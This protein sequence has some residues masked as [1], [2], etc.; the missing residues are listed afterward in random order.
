[1]Q[2]IR[3]SSAA[4]ATLKYTVVILLV[5]CASVVEAQKKVTLKKADQ[6]MGGKKGDEKYQ[7]LIGNVI[8]VQNN[9]TIYCDS[10]HFYKKRNSVEAFG[11]V[12]IVEGDSID[13]TGSRLEYDGN[14]KKAKLR[15]NVVFTKLA[16]ATLYTDYLDF[17]R[18]QNLAYYF[19]GGK[20][21][22][23][24]NTLTSNKGYYKTNTNLASFKKNVD[25]KN[26]DYTMQ[27]DSLQ[28]NSRTKIIYF[29]TETTVIN[30]D[31]STFVYQGGIY[32][33]V[34]KVSDVKK[35]T[36][37]SEAYTI[38]GERYD[39]DGIRNVGKVRGNVVMT[40]KKENLLIYGQASDHFKNT[41]YTKVYD[42]AY[43]A[44]VTEDN[45]TLFMSADTLISIDNVDPKKKRLLAY[46]NVKIFKT[47]MQGKADS[48]EYR[49]SDSTI[50]FYNKPVLW[51]EGNQMTADSI[52]ML[53]EHNTIS[54]IFLVANAFVISQDTLLNFNQI[55]GRRMTAE[56]A[57][58]KINKVI[59]LGNGESVYYALDD[60]TMSLMGMNKIICSNITI[61]FKEGKV[62]NLSFYVK[63]DA[64]FIPP[65][66]LKKEMRT[67]KGFN[68]KA[69]EKPLRDDV[70][71]KNQPVT[72][73]ALPQTKKAVQ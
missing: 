32:N 30:K 37:E 40:S 54:K 6:L 39:Y 27:A 42:H 52:R 38:V 56:L 73:P 28:Y 57:N 1:M 62:N 2:E 68:W 11:Y 3:F 10:A 7:R 34:S 41:G 58:S 31:S 15:N 24:L 20:L 16:T 13:I 23:S 19:N 8:F 53:I 21:V 60:K 46:H 70:V 71:Q 5:A 25:V 12:H 17:Y 9:T 44:K 55:K 33:T 66:E 4:A 48:L 72:A 61:R 45:D 14:T 50:Y 29:V 51:S 64:Q 47:N 49:P 65:H 43:V 63:P 22:D 59:V 67:L 26:P 18:S 69:E 35:G 36:G